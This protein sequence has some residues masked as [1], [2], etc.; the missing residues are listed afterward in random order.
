MPSKT[1]ASKNYFL[2]EIKE[3]KYKRT[4]IWKKNYRVLTSIIKRYEDIQNHAKDSVFT[5][6]QNID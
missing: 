1:K 6:L 3:L 2:Y 4:L 5:K